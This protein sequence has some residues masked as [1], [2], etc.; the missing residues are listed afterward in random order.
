MA[1]IISCGPSFLRR[2]PLTVACESCAGTGLSF[3]VTWRGTEYL[4]VVCRKCRG[5]GYL[6]NTQWFRDDPE[7]YFAFK[8]SLS[9]ELSQEK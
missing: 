1:D 7:K 4:R 5:E 8:K 9:N 6:P 3:F 2:E